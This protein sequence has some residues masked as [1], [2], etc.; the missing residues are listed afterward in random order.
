M[1]PDTANLHWLY[2]ETMNR[3]DLHA[4]RVAEGRDLQAA[5]EFA[6]YVTFSGL[7]KLF[8]AFPQPEPLKVDGYLLE[9]A[10]KELTYLVTERYRTNNT[11]AQIGMT[12]LEKINHKLE[13]IAGHMARAIPAHPAEPPAFTV[14]SGGAEMLSQPADS[15]PLANSG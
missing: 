2:R 8:K 11:Q 4:R 6:S 13:L 15:E 5:K 12:E 1:Q 9:H 3:L 10:A 7:V 14:I